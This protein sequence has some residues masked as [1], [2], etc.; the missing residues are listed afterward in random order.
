MDA[1]ADMG[2]ED[3]F[4]TGM[5]ASLADNKDIKELLVDM[6]PSFGDTVTN[7]GRSILTFTINKKDLEEHYGREQYAGLLGNIRKIFQMLGN[8]VYDL[9]SYINMA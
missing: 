6:V 5:L 1:A 4:D 7:L 9:K 8:V 3:L 2:D